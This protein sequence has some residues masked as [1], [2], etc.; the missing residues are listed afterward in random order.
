MASVVSFPIMNNP[1]LT[2]TKHQT[3]PKYR[4]FIIS[5]SNSLQKCQGHEIERLIN[6]QRLG[7]TKETEQHA[8]LDPGAEKN[9]KIWQNLNKLC[10]LVNTC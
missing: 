9:E 10:S 8:G 7:E 6:C 1:N 4:S 3:N 2:V 5:V